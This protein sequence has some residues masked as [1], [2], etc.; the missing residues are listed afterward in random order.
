MF[1]FEM[2]TGQPPAT[3]P[4]ISPHIISVITVSA[5]CAGRA[6]AWCYNIA[7]RTVIRYSQLTAISNFNI[8]WVSRF[9]K[10]V[11]MQCITNWVHHVSFCKCQQ[12]QHMIFL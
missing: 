5:F 12:Y 9:A 10:H 4:V 1:E 6:C 8:T 2:I 7:A 11:A 3:G